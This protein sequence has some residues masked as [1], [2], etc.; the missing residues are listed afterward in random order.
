LLNF[1]AN[2]WLGADLGA[3]SRGIGVLGI[4]ASRQKK[5]DRCISRQIFDDNLKK[6][7]FKRYN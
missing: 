4:P 3:K 6:Y 2:R 5:T 7:L 1:D